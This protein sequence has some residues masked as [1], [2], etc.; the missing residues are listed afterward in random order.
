M[1]NEIPEELFSILK[2]VMGSSNLDSPP[3]SRL[4]EQR[5]ELLMIGYREDKHFRAWLTL[6]MDVYARAVVERKID[7]FVDGFL[8]L[9][10]MLF[11]GEGR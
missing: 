1:N 11:G 10:K 9:Q 7:I 2:K 6:A 8:H 5:M 3:L 4:G